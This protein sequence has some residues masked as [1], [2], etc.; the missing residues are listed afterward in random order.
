MENHLKDPRAKILIISDE[1]QTAEI[2]GFSLHQVGLD[3]TLLAVSDPVMETWAA[4]SPD[5]IIIEDYNDQV[6]ELPLCR[7]LREAT[8][9]PIIYLTS[10]TSETFHLEIYKLGIDDCI[11]FP[12]SPRVFQAK[13][14]AWLRR[15]RVL[16]IA[17]LDEIRAGDFRL[18]GE[19]KRLALPSGDTVRLTTLEV[20]LLYLLMAHPARVFE[21]Q[22]I[23][24]K[25]WG[26]VGEGDNSLLKH[27]V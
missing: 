15:T 19:K 24:E 23:V 11:T 3:V 27:L 4:E 22:E 7:Q 6:E 8:V 10:K 12:V 25:V 21:H 14:N 1:P 17:A 16:P 20:R 13:V 2:W 18:Q 9:V 5:L 26:Y